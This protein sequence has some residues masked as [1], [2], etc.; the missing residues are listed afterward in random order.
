MSTNSVYPCF[1]DGRVS[2]NTIYPCCSDG[3]VSENTTLLIRQLLVLDPKA[4]LTASQVLDSLRV[5]IVTWYVSQGRLSWWTP[6]CWRL[7]LNPVVGEINV[8]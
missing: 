6:F 1:S 7:F 8:N 3:R 4:R 5:I 2:T